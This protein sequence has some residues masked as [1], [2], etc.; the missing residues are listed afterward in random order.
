MTP[1]EIRAA[2]WCR[3]LDAMAAPDTGDLSAEMLE[4]LRAPILKALDQRP[5]T[6]GTEDLLAELRRLLPDALIAG[7]P[8]AAVHDAVIAAKAMEKVRAEYD[9]KSHAISFAEVI[10]REYVDV[11]VFEL[12][13][14][15]E[16]YL[17]SIGIRGRGGKAVTAANIKRELLSSKKNKTS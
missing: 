4:A 2:L 9:W 14:A 7:D 11:P 12:A 5:I 17:D 10:R 15:I 1:E 8:V 6:P 3:M 16:K 13:Q